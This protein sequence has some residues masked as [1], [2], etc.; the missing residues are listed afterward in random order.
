MCSY[1]S[2]R[3]AA[4]LPSLPRPDNT[5]RPDF[6]RLLLD[7]SDTEAQYYQQYV[8]PAT[9]R[10]FKQMQVRCAMHKQPAVVLQ[11]HKLQVLLMHG[12][13]DSTLLSTRTKGL[14]PTCSFSCTLR[15]M[16]TAM[17]HINQVSFSKM[18]SSQGYAESCYQEATLPQ[19]F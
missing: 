19:G 16:F 10:A 12:A 4:G 18:T 11:V 14:L 3:P 7:G 6:E 15:H 5:T 8:R 9:M 1:F 17:V 2:G 13:I